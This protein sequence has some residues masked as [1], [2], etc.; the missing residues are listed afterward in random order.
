MSR[1]PTLARTA[2]DLP[3]HFPS[4][5]LPV[6]SPNPG[7]SPRSVAPGPY[8]PEDLPPRECRRQSGLS[9]EYPRE[10]MRCQRFLARPRRVQH[11]EAT[12]SL[13]CALALILSNL[14]ALWLGRIRD[15]NEFKGR[16]SP[17]SIRQSMVLQS[18]DFSHCS[19]SCLRVVF[20][21]VLFSAASGIHSTS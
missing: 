17:P 12:S 3:R 16:R 8:S 19:C 7:L 14:F 9:N 18:S 10:I 13:S 6:N 5:H 1:S 15:L 4:R 2:R 11:R 21:N 20:Y